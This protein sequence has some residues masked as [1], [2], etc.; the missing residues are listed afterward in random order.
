MTMYQSPPTAG[1]AK[2]MLSSRRGRQ[3]LTINPVIR[4]FYA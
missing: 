1:S 2:S 4:T 3:D